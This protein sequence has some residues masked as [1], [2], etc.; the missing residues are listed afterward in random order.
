MAA[1][2]AQQVLLE[3]GAA[4]EIEASAAEVAGRDHRA[5]EWEIHSAEAEAWTGSAQHLQKGKSSRLMR[6]LI[7]C[8]AFV[9]SS[10]WPHETPSA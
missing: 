2:P 6:G 7:H 5:V 9:F 10:R 8:A 1:A 4:A 3:V